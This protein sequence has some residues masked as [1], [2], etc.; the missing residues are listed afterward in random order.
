MV[1][2]YV[3]IVRAS[4]LISPPLYTHVIQLLF[5]SI[6]DMYFIFY[7]YVLWFFVCGLYYIQDSF[8]HLLFFSF[9]FYVC[10]GFYDNIQDSFMGISFSYIISM[11]IFIL[12]IID[13]VIWT[14][15]NLFFLFQVFG[16]GYGYI[17]LVVVLQDLYYRM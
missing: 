8:Y 12:F 4:S 5:D 13:Y 14:Y 2:R 3:Y 9:S 1:Q 17:I 16:L 11:M 6:F 10:L 15:D 7:I